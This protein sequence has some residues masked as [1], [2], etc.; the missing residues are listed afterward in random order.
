MTRRPKTPDEPL[1]EWRI[2][3]M[4]ERVRY[5]GPVATDKEGAIDK[6]ME[7]VRIEPARR[8]RLIVVPVE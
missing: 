7:E 5:L 3:I 4:R 6:A 8:F 1:R 2:S